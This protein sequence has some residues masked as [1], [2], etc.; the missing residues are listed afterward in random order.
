[1]LL[2]RTERLRTTDYKAGEPAPQ[3]STSD[4][5]YRVR[6]LYTAHFTQNADAGRPAWV[7]DKLMKFDMIYCDAVGGR[8]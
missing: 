8:R 3:L 6:D 4:D 7:G 2:A 5:A 1:M